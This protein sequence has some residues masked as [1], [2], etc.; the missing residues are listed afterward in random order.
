MFDVVSFLGTHFSATNTL[1]PAALRNAIP[2]F[3]SFVVLPL[4][5]NYPASLFACV[6]KFDS[7]PCQDLCCVLDVRASFSW[8]LCL[9][10]TSVRI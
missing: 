5:V 4:L 2:A 9:P 3:I 6:L 7:L 1:P 10:S 8:G